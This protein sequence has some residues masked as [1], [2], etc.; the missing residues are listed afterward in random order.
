MAKGQGKASASKTAPKKPV[1]VAAGSRLDQAPLT[2]K[3]IQDP[4]AAE[5]AEKEAKVED[6]RIGIGLVDLV[7]ASQVKFGKYNGRAL[8]KAEVKNLCNSFDSEG[9]DRFHRMNTIKIIVPKSYVQPN[10]LVQD[11]IKGSSEVVYPVARLSQDAPKPYE[12]ICVGG[13]HRSAAMAVTLKKWHSEIKKLNAELAEMEEVESEGLA[14][15]QVQW[16]KS[17]EKDLELKQSQLSMGGCGWRNS[18]MNR[19]PTSATILAG[20]SIELAMHM[21]RN[22]TKHVFKETEDERLVM[23]LTYLDTL[24]SPAER[25]KHLQTQKLEGLKET[26]YLVFNR[27]LSRDENIRVLCWMIHVGDHFATA[28]EMTAKWMLGNLSDTHG[29]L[30]A[31]TCER[32]WS[33]LGYCFSDGEVEEDLLKVWLA[34]YASLG[35]ED[36]RKLAMAEWLDSTRETVLGSIVHG[37]MVTSDLLDEIDRRAVPKFTKTALAAFGD[38]NNDEWRKCYLQYGEEVAE[39]LAEHAAKYGDS[40]GYKSLQNAAA[41]WKFILRDEIPYGFG[42]PALTKSLLAPLAQYFD[43]IKHSLQEIMRWFDGVVDHN[44]RTTRGFNVGCRSFAA[45]DSIQ[46]CGQLESNA[47][48]QDKLLEMIAGKYPILLSMDREISEMSKEHEPRPTTSTRLDAYFAPKEAMPDYA[49]KPKQGKRA[50][51]K[52][53]ATATKPEVKVTPDMISRTYERDALA[54]AIKECYKKRAEFGRETLM[55]SYDEQTTPGR[56]LAY[57]TSWPIERFLDKSHG[58]EISNV[59][60][61]IMFER[62]F[63]I[64]KRK[65]LLDRDYSATA[66]IRNELSA[67]LDNAT[68]G[69]E[70]SYIWPDQL[71]ARA[72]ETHMKTTTE[73]QLG[74]IAERKLIEKQGKEIQTVINAVTRATIA[75][76]APSEEETEEEQARRAQLHSEVGPILRDLIKVLQKN[77]YRHRNEEEPEF[78]DFTYDLLRER[79][80]LPVTIQGKDIPFEELYGLPKDDDDANAPEPPTTSDGLIEDEAADEHPDEDKQV[81]TTAPAKVVTDAATPERPAAGII[82]DSPRVRPTSPPD[83]EGSTVPSRHEPENIP[84]SASRGPDNAED[85][86]RRKPEAAGGNSGEGDQQGDREDKNDTVDAQ[87]YGALAEKSTTGGDDEDYSSRSGDRQVR[88]SPNKLHGI[89]T[90]HFPAAT[91]EAAGTICAPLNGQSVAS[92]CSDYIL[93]FSN[94]ADDF[95]SAE[96]SKPLDDLMDFDER[97]GSRGYG[98]QA[99]RSKRGAADDPEMLMDFHD[100]GKQPPI[101]RRY[102]SK[103]RRGKRAAVDDLD[104][105]D[106]SRNKMAKTRRTE[107]PAAEATKAVRGKLP[108]GERLNFGSSALGGKKGKWIYPK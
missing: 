4:L 49:E 22:E 91:D 3:A 76:H 51:K 55:R 32:M 108:S 106:D 80:Y 9:V 107:A 84:D 33:R 12:L 37:E 71:V 65:E 23:Q 87:D 83:A 29:A 40:E 20:N 68:K 59:A 50:E 81:E 26:G 61:A 17:L 18:T 41:K 72:Q 100:R 58:R 5:R 27:M 43:R 24:S 31:A 57:A 21:S 79:V 89:D 77:A 53:E 78:E 39:V 7:D 48:I 34:E 69:T 66:E 46:R 11:F 47:G 94:S 103:A 62:H 42:L 90:R 1:T 74:V 105:V 93:E 45:M 102:E 67:I 19:S 6:A 101:S 85:L 99:R 52:A 54:K 82:P 56:H 97:G 8:V 96:F 25:R 13:R 95:Q 15:E 73:E 75:R 14:E 36:P 30:F 60:N 88:P 16:R 44:I 104:M 63:V 28:K 64:P 92:G 70:T 38:I 35:D 10:S 98:S 2:I 86:G